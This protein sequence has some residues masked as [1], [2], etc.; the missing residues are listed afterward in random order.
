M[1]EYFQKIHPDVTVEVWHMGSG[2]STGPGGLG[3][4]VKAQML[5]DTA[6]DVLP[7]FA[8]AAWIGRPSICWTLRIRPKGI[9]LEARRLLLQS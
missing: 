8:V 9:G 3:D 2:G 1:T 5:T 7:G 4:I 6:A